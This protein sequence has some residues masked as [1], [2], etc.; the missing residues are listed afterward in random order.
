MPITMTSPRIIF[1]GTPEFAVASL[2]ALVES[3][4]APC[5]VLTQPDRRAGRGKRL[6]MSPVKQ[7]AIEQKIEVGQPVSLRDDSVVEELAR[8]EP[9]IMVVAAYGLILPQNVL[10]VPRVGC[11]NVHASLLPR[12][13]GAAPIQAAILAGDPETGVCL[14]SMEAGLDTGPVYLSKT[15]QIGKHE[16]A[17]ELHDRLAAVGAGMLA[18]NIAAI[19]DGEL[20]ATPQD[21]E[22]ATYAPKIKSSDA[23]LDWKRPA[24][25][26]ERLV[27]AYN[28]TPGAWFLLDDQRIKV[29]QAQCIAAVDAPPGTV[30]A[31]KQDGIVVSCGDGALQLESLQRPGKRAVTAAE[32]A[33]QFDLPGRQL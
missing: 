11:L 12:W 2:E 18:N 24:I 32:F 20:D 1:A 4:V 17:G 14:M 8:L 29:W 21:D 19:I 33:A 16:T 7:Y 5:L 31:A 26:L 22:R 25:D 27:R 10:D 28:P 15:V 13:R 30:V 3:G 6:T 9:D 23:A